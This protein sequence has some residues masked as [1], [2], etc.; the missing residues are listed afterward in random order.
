MGP[1]EDRWPV[2]FTQLNRILNFSWIF[3]SERCLYSVDIYLLSQPDL[4]HFWAELPP[5]CSGTREAASSLRLAPWGPGVRA[6][7]CG[8]A[9]GLGMKAELALWRLRQRLG[10]A[11]PSGGLSLVG[12]RMKW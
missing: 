3:I 7:G 2:P 12:S 10:T 8:P 5:G 9:G 11:L 1:G 4:I 6:K